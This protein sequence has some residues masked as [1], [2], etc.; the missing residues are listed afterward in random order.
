MY[1]KIINLIL[2]SFRYT[3]SS[4]LGNKLRAML[5]LIGICL[6][7]FSIVVVL[8]LIDSL[9]RDLYGQIEKLGKDV[10]Y[11]QKF[12]WAGGDG[13]SWRNFINRPSATFNELKYLQ[14]ECKGAD[15]IS[16]FSATAGKLIKYRDRS[17]ENVTLIGTSFEYDRTNTVNIDRGRYFTE[18]EIERK[19]GVIILGASVAES[20]FDIV[21]PIGQPVLL[22][23]KRFKVIGLLEKTGKSLFNEEDNTVLIPIT[24]FKAFINIRSDITNPTLV[25]K[26]KK[27]VSLEELRDELVGVMR[28]VRRL[29]PVSR[30]NFAINDLNLIESFLGPIFVQIDIVGIIIGLFSLLVGA[31]G[32]SNIMIVSV[33]ERV[34][35]I[36]IQKALGAKKIFILFQFLFESIILCIIGGSASLL[37]I[38]FI[39]YGLNTWMDIPLVF[40]LG[41]NNVIFGLALS[42]IVGVASGFLPARSAA[43][44]HPV[45]AIRRGD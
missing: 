29:K 23:G 39:F 2:E 22:Y 27:D 43:R 31:F 3:I 30:N 10:L 13:M 14:E 8:S 44:L 33:K 18:E 12:P 38:F 45:D 40:V 32:I 7:V 42:V 5:S 34:G 26:A 25:V 20:L 41:W 35:E 19:T 6:G 9:K 15:A 4:L 37:L 1:R 16:F 24:K 21:D 17:V 11:I 28:G 36:G